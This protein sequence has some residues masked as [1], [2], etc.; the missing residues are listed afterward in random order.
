MGSLL[1]EPTTGKHVNVPGVHHIRQTVGNKENTVVLG[2]LPN[3]FHN[4]F[5]TFCI[6]IG[7]SLIKNVYGRIV[8]QSSGQSQPLTLTAGKVAAPFHQFSIQ[9]SLAF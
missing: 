8:Q 7:S 5:F 3:H 1:R 2:Q 4:L 9:T 6:N